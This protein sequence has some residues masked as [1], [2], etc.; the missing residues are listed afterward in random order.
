MT[1]LA[2]ELR[3]AAEEAVRHDGD[4]SRAALRGAELLRLALEEHEDRGEGPC[5]AC[6]TGTLDGGWR[7]TATASLTEL[8][9]RSVAA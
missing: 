3:Q 8:R 5:P 1:R 9:R 6:A 2:G 4:R 7:A